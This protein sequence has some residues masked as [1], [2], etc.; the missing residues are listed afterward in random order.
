MEIDFVEIHWPAYRQCTDFLGLVGTTNQFCT[1]QH[2][3]PGAHQPAGLGSI[4][5][6]S[7]RI[8]VVDDAGGPMEGVEVEARPMIPVD[9]HSLLGWVAQPAGQGED[10]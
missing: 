1:S 3:P 4:T 9:F 7:Q 5:N 2:V 6:R 10:H 8:F